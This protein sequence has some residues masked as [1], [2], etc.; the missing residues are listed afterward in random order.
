MMIWQ[1][2]GLYLWIPAKR[3]IPGA[4]PEKGPS[5]PEVRHKDE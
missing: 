2:L 1:N 4:I 5:D 3:T